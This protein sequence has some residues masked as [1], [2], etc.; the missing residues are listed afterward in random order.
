[1][2]E[3]KLFTPEEA[4][5]TL[6]LVRKIVEDILNFGKE[7][8]ELSVKI[9]KG[10]EEDPRAIQLMDKLDELFDELEALGCTYKDWNFIFGLVDFP[11]RIDG[12]EVCLCWRSDEREIGYYHGL[13]EGFAGRK[14]LP[15][16]G[17]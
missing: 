5:K 8:R 13:E 1:M 2:N 12:K 16:K 14:P 17:A 4:T 7:L 6:P 15:G 3:V 10:A 11:A 9:G